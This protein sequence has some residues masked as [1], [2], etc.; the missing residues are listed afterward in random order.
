MDTFSQ[1]MDRKI[2]AIIRGAAPGDAQAIASALFE[3]GIT[4]IEVTFNSPDP[5]AVI[6]EMTATWGE[7]VLVGAGTVLDVETARAAVAAGAR[8]ILSPMLDKGIIRATKDAGGVS[9]PGA[10]TPTEILDAFRSGADIIKVFPAS[11]G[12]AYIRDIRGPF[13]HI[14]LMP[15][16]GVN[17]SNIRTFLQAGAVAFGVGSALVDTSRPVNEEYLQEITHKARLLT[18]AIKP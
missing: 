2:V 11:V 9:I 17:L 13:P 18:E 16:G 8:F 4:M 6:S 10:F 15:T 3:G 12:P 7:R 14:P 5:V 1:I